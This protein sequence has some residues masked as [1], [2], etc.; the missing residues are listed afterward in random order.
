MSD[1][2][3]EMRGFII[4]LKLTRSSIKT[5][6]ESNYRIFYPTNPK[7]LKSDKIEEISYSLT[8][9]DWESY[10]FIVPKEEMGKYPFLEK[11]LKYDGKSKYMEICPI[12]PDNYYINEKIEAVFENGFRCKLSPVLLQHFKVI[13]VDTYIKLYNGQ[14]WNDNDSEG[15]DLYFFP[16]ERKVFMKNIS[17]ND[18]KNP[19]AEY[20]RNSLRFQGVYSNDIKSQ[21][22][23]NDKTEIEDDMK[24]TI[25]DNVVDNANYDEKQLFISESRWLEK[26]ELE[27]ID[28]G[29]VQYALYMLW[30]CKNNLFY[31]GKA[32][33]L[34]TR[35]EQ[36]TDAK[37]ELIR[38]FTHFRYS[39]LKENYRHLIYMFEMH[40]IH[41]AGWI[42]STPNANKDY[43]QALPN[44]K[45][46]NNEN[47]VSMVNTVVSYHSPF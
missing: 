16:S 41:T 35:L 5:L 13:F 4:H 36:H 27:K 34:R 33:D 42:L 23:I 44:C 19:Y 28:I 38:N 39:T 14:N 9:F 18:V 8:D 32:K 17:L 20:I 24:D 11:E 1:I 30:D 2:K 3:S 26:S 31:I 45:S 37:D 29:W 47:S 15:A 21:F 43:L 7:T 22:N 6:F 12:S 10:S 25:E 40:E 46:E